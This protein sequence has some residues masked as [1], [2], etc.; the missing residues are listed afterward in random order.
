MT[1]AVSHISS[2]A[3]QVIIG[4][5]THKDQHVAVAIDGRG[6]RLDEKQ[7]PVA[8]CGYEELER[9]SR[10]LGQIHAFGMEGTGSYG[11]GLACFLTERSHTV[12]EVNRP[13]RSVRYR[14][15]KSD[16]TDAE[17]AA[18]SVLAGVADATP[19]SGEGEV[20]MIRM[21][22]CAKNSAVVART[23]AVNQ[24]KALVVTAPA[25]L[26][27][28][29][30]GL[31]TSTLVKRCGS[32]RPG[33]LDT[34]T[35]AAKYTLRSLACR[36]RQLNKE[37]QDLKAELQ[38]LIQTTAPALVKAFGVGP[39]TAASLLIA[40]GS[41]PDRLHS[42]AAFAS[43]CGV[44]PVPASSGKTNRHRLNRGGDRQA[45]AALYRIV[46]VRLCHDLRTQEYLRRRTAEGVTK[47]EVI[48]C[49]KRYVARE[50]YSIIQ[51]PNQILDEAA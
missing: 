32:F 17:M 41:N 51:K 44:N 16:P 3:V 25:E 40:A 31:G 45:N 36:Y 34:P 50:V 21:L 4:V 24:M 14:K 2:R 22:K 13:D 15:G 12:V 37:I 11:A 49:L 10:S 42:E 43:L 23:Q 7:V 20:E 39:D 28:K 18:R 5:D 6:V 38:R 8:V 29:L 27:E 26:R 30:D 1:G 48:R 33:H 47:I 9:W 46:V 19:K 35:A